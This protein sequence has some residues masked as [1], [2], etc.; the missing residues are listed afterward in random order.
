MRTTLAIPWRKSEATT[1]GKGK[2]VCQPEL[3]AQKPG[4]AVHGV[5]LATNDD[6]KE[7]VRG[8]GP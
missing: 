8:R 2:N 1:E 3:V 5:A 4:E 6:R 7:F